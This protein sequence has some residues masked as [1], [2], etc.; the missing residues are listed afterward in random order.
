MISFGVEVGEGYR[1]S[2]QLELRQR[3]DGFAWRNT[4]HTIYRQATQLLETI[5]GYVRG[6]YSVI[7]VT[8]LR[9]LV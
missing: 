2:R 7:Q 8:R 1:S 4:N 6:F 9:S 3:T 5:V